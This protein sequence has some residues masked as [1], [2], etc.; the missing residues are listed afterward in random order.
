[1]NHWRHLR[2]KNLAIFLVGIFIAFLL[3]QY[4]PFQQFLL[5][6]GTL[7]YIGAFFAGILFVLSFTMPIG[8]VI[9]FLLAEKLSP[10]EIGLI[11]GSG[12]VIGDFAIFHFVKDNL[13]EELKPL[14]H[15]FGGDHV[16]HVLH[17]K[18]FHWTLPV[19]G[20][21]IIAS[22]FPDEVGVSLMGISKMKTYK[23]V[24]ISFLL[25]VTGIFLIIS[26]SVLLTR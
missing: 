26:A 14:Y 5:T 19:L 13:F 9:L 16:S 2:Y 11:A 17:S 10:L 6:L 3:S 23:F 18:Y 8:S 4:Q 25:N 21:F 20:A 15:R 1:M 24:I 22:P 12:A 7:G